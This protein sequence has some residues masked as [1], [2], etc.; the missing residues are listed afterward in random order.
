MVLGCESPADVV[1]PGGKR[2]VSREGRRVD[3]FR[4]FARHGRLCRPWV[5]DHDS[6]LRPHRRA[7]SQTLRTSGLVENG[8]RV[9]VDRG[10]TVLAAPVAGIRVAIAS[11][12]E[13]RRQ[14][15][16]GYPDKAS[17]GHF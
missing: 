17:L 7:K 16:P 10:V 8:H 12:L 5:V 1:G 9:A 15:L 6:T 4:Y 13:H 2:R 14:L 3:R 11:V